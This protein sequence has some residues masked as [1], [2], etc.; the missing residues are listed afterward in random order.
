MGS[1]QHDS[2]AARSRVP[3]LTYAIAIACVGAFLFSA[4]ASLEAEAANE[5]GLAEAEEFLSDHPYL[6]VPPVLDPHLSAETRAL[7]EEA[8]AGRS[9]T[10]RVLARLLDREQSELDG[11]VEEAAQ[12]LDALPRRRFGLRADDPEPRAVASHVLVHGGWLH[13]IGNLALLVLLGSYLEGAFRLG[14][15]S[16]VA[17]TGVLGSAL[18]FVLFNPGYG[19]A[20][21][22]VGG[23]VAG[24]VGA[25]AIRFRG[26]DEEA[27]YALPLV[28]ASLGLALPAFLG[29]EW[30]IARGVGSA[31]ALVGAVNPSIWALLGG[32]FAGAG[33]AFGVRLVGLERRDREAEVEKAPRTS[34]LDPQFQRALEL[35]RAGQ[36]DEAFNL[37]TS[38]LRRFPDD[39]D[40]SEALWQVANEL[41]RPRAAS[42][43]ILR[44]IRE[45]IK[46]EDHEAAIHLWL[47]IA[48][49]DLDVTADTALLL[50]MAPLLRQRGAPDVA[51]RALRAALDSA[52]DGAAS[53]RVATR[54][55]QEAADLDQATAR[56]AAWRALGSPELGIEA[57]Q[58][59]ESLLSVIQPQV[60]DD[61]GDA[62]AEPIE[63]SDT[64]SGEDLMAPDEAEAA[65][66]AAV[67]AATRGPSPIELEE[68]SRNLES[69]LGE[70]IGLDDQG[71]ILELEGG[72]K[73][74]L[75]YDRIE[76]IGVS[77]VD[78]VGDKAVLVVDLIL[79][80][81]SLSRDPLRLIR[82]RTDRFD[83][84][85]LVPSAS[86]PLQALRAILNR[87]LEQSDAIPLPDLQSV[88]GTPFAAFETLAEYQAHVLMVGEG[89]K[90]S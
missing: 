16:A 87:L 83:P 13:L 65:L 5:V 90:A 19:E 79:N 8:P 17:I 82:M 26:T 15:F 53:M 71:I 34:I 7:L 64:L 48:A 70:A 81:V 51:V 61:P 72:L 20:L 63:P 9:G 67:A 22:G 43:A 80:W 23:L 84:R 12:R 2:R 73:K 36:L 25:Y 42:A 59:L 47:E 3:W 33:A 76:A 14:V 11:L 31:P 27:P 62:D 50:R 38:V 35:Q 1:V 77:A 21:I 85:Q 54:V 69:I 44:V 86:D 4:K 68:S 60:F 49:C 74:R 56:D 40:A 58:E 55:A 18:A 75:A 89:R 32:G 24:L 78:G 88:Q 39:L 29:F 57:R 52:V 28:I 6:T 45:K 10:R 37:L 41:G 46:R 66:D 30:S